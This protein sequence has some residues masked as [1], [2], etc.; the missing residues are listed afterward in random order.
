MK[1]TNFITL[2]AL[3][4]VLI[5]VICLISFC[6]LLLFY[7]DLFPYTQLVTLQVGNNR[8]VSIYEDSC[9]E[10]SK[11]VYYEVYEAGKL[12]AP[13]SYIG[14]YLGS[15]PFTLE[16][17]YAENQSLVGGYDAAKSTPELLFII[18]FKTGESWPREWF[19]PRYDEIKPKAVDLFT[20]LQKENPN[21]KA[22]SAFVP[23]PTVILSLPTA[24]TTPIEP[25]PINTLVIPASG[26][27]ETRQ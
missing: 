13:K 27:S 9:W 2:R 26:T 6:S 7:C 4:M 8:S 16:V 15:E 19:D 25:T 22:A 11:K 23:T 21:I 14:Q 3:A 10:I 24:N 1:V 12:I 18:D 17:I 20:R 5:P